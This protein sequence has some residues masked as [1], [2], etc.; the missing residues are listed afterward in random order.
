MDVLDNCTTALNSQFNAATKCTPFWSLYGRHW[1]VELPD[2]PTQN[3]ISHD[4]LAYG[5][6]VSRAAS[7]AQKY[8]AICNKDA[9][10]L[11]DDK[12]RKMRSKSE[13]IVG[14]KVRLYRPRAA[15]NTDKMPWIGEYEVLDTNGLVSK[16]TNGPM[17]FLIESKNSKFQSQISPVPAFGHYRGGSIR[18][19]EVCRLREGRR[20]NP[21]QK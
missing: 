9:D 6:N 10:R 19:L 14:S 13:I 20:I 17:S 18:H 21:S 7:M 3:A 4:P 15:E 8:V 12:A 11:L 2:P 16:I 1:N 5:M